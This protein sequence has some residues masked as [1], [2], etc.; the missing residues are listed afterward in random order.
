MIKLFRNI[1]KNLLNEGKTSK[2]F[3]YA[4]GEIVLVVIGILIALSINN[5]NQNRKVNKYLSQVYTQLQKDLQTDTLNISQNIE[6]YSQKNNRLTDIIERNIP[7]SYYDTINE[8]NYTNCEKCRS[9]LASANPFKNLDKGYQLLK[10]LNTDQSNKL[11]SL[12]FK[13]DAF[14]KDYNEVFP[15][16]YKLLLKYTTET[17]DDYQQYNW[18]VEWSDFKHRNYNK[19]FVTYIFESEEYRT[20]CARRL[21]YSKYYLYLLKDYKTNATEVLKLLD[22]KLKE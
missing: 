9:D 12:S 4:I 13:I 2:Y 21:I 11:D 8:T 1:R 22:K 5:W 19:E 3:K 17:I 20:K 10:S 16:M 18:F 14:Y 15:E 7:I 6:Y